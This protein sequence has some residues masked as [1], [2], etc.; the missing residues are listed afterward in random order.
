MHA[1]A[2][3]HTAHQ[4]VLPAELAAVA[5]VHRRSRVVREGGRHATH[6]DVGQLPQQP[7]AQDVLVDGG[8]GGQRRGR[9]RGRGRGRVQ[10]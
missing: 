3:M 5:P 6:A 10:C 9:G 7:Q 1:A 2:A 8:R 4:H